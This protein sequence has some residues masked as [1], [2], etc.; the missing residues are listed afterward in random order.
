MCG[1]LALADWAKPID[2]Q[3]VARGLSQLR[4]RGPDGEG[5]ATRWDGRLA[6]AHRRLAIFDT[7]DG[8]RQPM[9][10]AASGDTIVFNGSIYNYP[11]L[12]AELEQAGH[13]FASD[14]DTE[15]LLAA[16]RQWGHG[17]FARLNGMW[18][19]VL[20][21][22]ASDSVVISRDRLGVKPL[23]MLRDATRTALAS[24]VRALLAATGH[25]P[26]LA[27]DA[28][29]D[30][31]LLGL[32]DHG[33]RTML[34]GVV[35]V[36]PGALWT[37]SRDGGLSRDQFHRWPA[38]EPRLRADDVAGTL[39]ELLADATA[40]RLRA[41]VPVA[42]LLSGGLDSGTVAWA[43]TRRLDAEAARRFVGFTSYG[44]GDGSP[45]DETA[46]A[47]ATLR[48]LGTALP[49]VE[50]RAHSAPGL[51]DLE[52]FLA[53]QELPVGTPSPVAGFR[54]FRHLAQAGAKVVLTGDGSDE[55]FAGYTRRYLP[56]ALR[57]A[58]LAGT[59]G[60]AAV[61]ARSPH[62]D[63]G[64]ALARAAWNLPRPALA[65]LLARRPHVA[66]LERD[67]RDACPGRLD[68]LIQMQR[69]G[70]E[71]QGPRDVA[72]HLLPQVLRYIDRNSMA[73][74]IE[75]RSPFLDYR[76]AELAARLPMAAKVGATGGKLPVRR[77]MAPHLPANVVNGAKARGLG[78][79]EQ[80]QVGRLDLRALLAEPPA[81][82]AGVIN[83]RRLGEMLARHPGDPRLWWPVCLLLWLRQVER[84]WN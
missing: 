38:P 66:V 74:G 63:R 11:E 2:P 75:A 79:A 13:R 62:L 43:V 4:H 46:E 36:P 73:W 39:A 47:R 53:T 3:Q 60:A 61:L 50:V 33:G 54:L 51:D 8:G 5:T 83:T 18:A 37:L 80:F 59:W 76:V 84:Q 56:M 7:G 21:D 27:A 70:L 29:F 9:T 20:H 10:R 57:D 58:A 72:R 35:E 28:A 26:R 17:A 32:S 42:A 14:S 12:R 23:Y 71:E 6:L 78:H 24:E 40:L 55:L 16:W 67:F 64:A 68:D 31:L 1:I 65:A 25:A 34:D 22:A 19:L 82:A 77:A 48:H 30:F 44:Y 69:S 15:V 49:H 81:A 45:Y 41:H 52:A